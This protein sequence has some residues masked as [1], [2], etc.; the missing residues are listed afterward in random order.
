M[1]ISIL[2]SLAQNLGKLARVV[3]DRRNATQEIR[4][5]IKNSPASA[6]DTM[7]GS[8]RVLDSEGN[9]MHETTSTDNRVVQF[10]ARNGTEK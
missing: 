3:I 10:P 9:A 1:K 7:L 6:A 5:E 4:N 8:G 2:L